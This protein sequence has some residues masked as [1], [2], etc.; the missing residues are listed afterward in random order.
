MQRIE[1]ADL[2]ALPGHVMNG[3]GGFVDEVMVGGGDGVEDDA[4][5]GDGEALQEPL[6][7]EE[8]ERVVDRGAGN[9]GEALADAL[10]DQIRRGVL[11]RAQNIVRHRHA[12]RRGLDAAFAE[13]VFDLHES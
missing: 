3:P 1:I 12:L 7:H 5:F 6:F 8:V 10:P 2:D 4:V 11:D 13:G 9:P